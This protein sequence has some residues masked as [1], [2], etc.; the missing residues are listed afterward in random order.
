M[1]LAEDFV[2][3]G[4]TLSYG[5]KIS[6]VFRDLAVEN[7]GASP[8]EVTDEMHRRGWL[9]KLDTVIDIADQMKDLR[10]KGIL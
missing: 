1:T 6:M 4:N 9:S 5:Q 3:L 10:S 2:T 7:G 8:A